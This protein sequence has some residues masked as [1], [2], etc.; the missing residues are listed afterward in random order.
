MIRPGMRPIMGLIDQAGA[1]AQA[2]ANDGKDARLLA[3]KRNVPALAV[4]IN[5]VAGT[6]AQM[7][8]GPI[9]LAQ[10]GSKPKF[11][12]PAPASNEFAGRIPIAG[13][14]SRRDTV[15]EK[16]LAANRP[17]ARPA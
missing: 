8:A 4:P 13:P 10:G 1:E 9:A 14:G 16:W 3:L 15:S 6:L 17:Q 7:G 12:N 5:Q 2:V 11:H